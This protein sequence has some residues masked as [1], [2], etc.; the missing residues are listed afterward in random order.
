M[1]TLPKGV[2]S[3]TDKSNFIYYRSSITYKGKHISLG[4]YEDAETAH[5][6][7]KEADSILYSDNISISSYKQD[8]PLS[9]EKWVVLINYRDNGLYLTTPIYVRPKFFYYYLSPNIVLTFDTDELF[10]YSSHKIMRRDGHLFVADYGMQLNIINRYGIKNYSTPGK[11]YLFKNGNELDFRRE[12]IE[13]INP[14]F[15]VRKITKKSKVL[16]QAKINVPGYYIIGYYQTDVEA[17]IAY[18]KAIDILKKKGSNRK[19][20]PNYI[21]YLSAREYA[22]LYSKIKISNKIQQLSF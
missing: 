7:Y 18:N 11:D 15:G 3:A 16:Y 12:N 1:N 5:Y 4:S 14:F 20:T 10:F 13:I 22:D 17:A 21:E 19:Y 9:F 6:A 2:Y 8:S